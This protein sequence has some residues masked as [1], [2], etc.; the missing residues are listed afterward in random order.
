[1][2]TDGTTSSGEKF[3]YYLPWNIGG[4]SCAA[5]GYG[6]MSMFTPTTPSS[7]WI[8]YQI[9]YG[10]GSGAMISTVSSTSKFPLRARDS[11]SCS[12]QSNQ[13]HVAHGPEPIEPAEV[14]APFR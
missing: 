3:G 14:C 5:I 9:L 1:M 8:G 11:G 4:A 6:L 12:L 2:V 7:K 13:K 10:I